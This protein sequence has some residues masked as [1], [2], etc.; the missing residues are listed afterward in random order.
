MFC[1]LPA[2][3]DLLPSQPLP[4]ERRLLRLVCEG[5]LLHLAWRLPKGISLRLERHLSR[6]KCPLLHANLL[7]DVEKLLFHEENQL[8]RLVEHF[9]HAAFHTLSNP[10]HY[11]HL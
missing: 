3:L 9:Y 1:H 7:A 11:S 4:Q 10:A 8:F 5:L 6:A 2:W